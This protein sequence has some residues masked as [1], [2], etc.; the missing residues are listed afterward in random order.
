LSPRARREKQI[1]LLVNEGTAS[2][3]EVFASALHDNGRTVAVIGTKT[4]GKGI[5][6][7]TFPMPDGGGLRLTVAE[8]LTP[9]LRHVTHVGGAQF[10]PRTGERIGGGIKP[11]IYCESKHGIPGNVGADL[12]VGMALDAL[13]E[14]DSVSQQQPGTFRLAGI[15]SDGIL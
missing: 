14:S 8:Y 15:R 6:Q 1:V 13:E 10:D 12:C 4:F 3:A 9:S 5:I 11:D 2:S 7:H